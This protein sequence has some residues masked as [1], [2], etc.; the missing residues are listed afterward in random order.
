MKIENIELDREKHY[1]DN[2]TYVP[3]H[4]NGDAAHPDCDRGVIIDF[5]DTV[6]KVLYCKGRTVQS[7]YPTDLVW[8]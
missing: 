8:G 6:V 2:V 7:T 4:A 5:N 3:G 1:L